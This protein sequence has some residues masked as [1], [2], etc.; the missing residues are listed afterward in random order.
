MISINQISQDFQDF[1]KMV[2]VVKPMHSDSRP[3]VDTV[4]IY[5]ENH[6]NECQEFSI[7]I[8][9][10][11]RKSGEKGSLPLLLEDSLVLQL[12]PLEESASHR[13]GEDCFA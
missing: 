13:V 12:C 2:A 8:R 10:D 5:V 9:F 11:N 4:G 1:V 7:W 6:N 3:G